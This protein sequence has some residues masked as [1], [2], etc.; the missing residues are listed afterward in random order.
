YYAQARGDYEAARGYF[1]EEAAL[2]EQMDD[3]E[4]HFFALLNLG[5][6]EHVLGQYADALDHHQRALAIAEAHDNRIYRAHALQSMGED[7]HRLDDHIAARECLDRALALFRESGMH[8]K[9]DE[10]AAYMR[11]ANYP[12]D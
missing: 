11:S 12:V 7:H 2:A 8:A 10:V 5:S 6:A 3:P 4:A 9:A 1:A